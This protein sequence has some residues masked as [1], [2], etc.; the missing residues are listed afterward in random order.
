VSALHLDQAFESIDFE[1][2]LPA[3]IP[4][5]WSRVAPGVRNRPLI[6]NAL[7]D[8][9]LFEIEPG[10]SHVLGNNDGPVVLAGVAGSVDATGKLRGRLTP[11]R[12]IARCGAA[13]VKSGSPSW[14]EITSSRSKNSS[15]CADAVEVA[16]R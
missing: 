6:R 1:D 7:F 9:D 15:T 12:S 11:A 13:Q 5:I 4:E 2:T 8:I 3:L 16:G 14:N 10:R